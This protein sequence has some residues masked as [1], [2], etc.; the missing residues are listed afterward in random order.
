MNRMNQII[1]L[2]ASIL[3]NENIPFQIFSICEKKCRFFPP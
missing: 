2:A 1:F 3:S